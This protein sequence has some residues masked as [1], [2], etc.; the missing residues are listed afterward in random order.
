MAH[1]D[2]IRDTETHFII[3]PETRAITT[4]SPGN[5]IVVQYDHNSERYTFEIP[6]YVDGHDMTESTE[7]RVH[8]KNGSHTGLSKTEG[9]YVCRDITV[10]ADDENLVTFTWAL[11]SATSQYIGYL[12]F[13]IQFVCLDGE[14]IEYA[15]NTGVYKDITVIESLNNNESA[16]TSNVDALTAYKNEIIAEVLAAVTSQLSAEG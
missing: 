9:V 7:V 3:D 10:S 5:N 16:M 6:R 14:T 13:A 12:H 4:A 8:Y 15:W 11:S 2:K 1:V